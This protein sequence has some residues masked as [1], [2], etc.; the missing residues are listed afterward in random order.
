M[1][2]N[3]PSSLSGDPI[4]MGISVSAPISSVT[5]SSSLLF[6]QPILNGHVFASTIVLIVSEVILF[7]SRR[8]FNL[9]S[10]P[11]LDAS[12]GQTVQIPLTELQEF[13]RWIANRSG[14]PPELNLINNRINMLTDP[15]GQIEGQHIP[16]FV[17][18]TT[19]EAP[20]VISIYFTADYSTSPFTPSV[21]M[22]IP[23]FSFP[24]IRGALPILIIGLLSTIFIRAVV[25]P[26]STG[27]SPLPRSETSINNPL[28]FSPNDLLQ[29]LTKFRNKMEDE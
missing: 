12:S 18:V 17:T 27:S 9:K 28:N 21:A 14:P 11:I 29:L 26:E 8:L 1:S 3:Q 10:L 4:G 19:P 7:I 15:G 25:S 22:F 2:G 5:G 24:G 20:L 6:A 23:I 16:S 13:L